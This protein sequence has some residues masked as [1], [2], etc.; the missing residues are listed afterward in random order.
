[1]STHDPNHDADMT[2][3]WPINRPVPPPDDDDATAVVPRH[4]P[5]PP[6]APPPTGPMPPQYGYGQPANP[7]WPP[8]S[9]PPAQPSGGWQP[10]H[11]P[12]QYPFA[13]YP[14]GAPTSP[15]GKKKP[16]GLTAAVLIAVVVLVGAGVYVLG[17]FGSGDTKSDTASTS[18]AATSSAPS[19]APSSTTSQAPGAGASE[20]VDTAALPTLLASVTDLNERFTGNFKPAAAVQSEPFDGLT[21]EPSNCAGALLPGIDYVYRTANY[22]GFAG[23]ILTDDTTKV[24]VMQAVIAF[25][26][27]TEATRFYNG[28]FSAWRGCNY[29]EVNTEGGGEQQT[30]KMGVAADTD[31]TAHMLMWKDRQGSDRACERGMTPRK[32]VVVDVRVCSSNIG[33]SGFT[34]ARDIGAK[35]TGSR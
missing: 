15:P 8:Q 17:D 13:G 34:L 31:G 30:V 16:R 26:T 2:A 3:D 14:A 24:A 23:Q 35:V 32:N 1:M 9:S 7:G 11:P 5:V 20:N 4:T 33:S 21:V 27:E 18:S 10:P 19:E 29:S 25:N 6:S 12:G 28:Q 22:S